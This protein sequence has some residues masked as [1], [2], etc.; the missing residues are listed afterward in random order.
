MAAGRGERF[1]GDKLWTPVAGLTILEMALRRVATCDFDVTVL[2][3]AEERGVIATELAHR[4]GIDPVVTAGGPTR[5]DSVRRGLVHAGRVDMIAVHDAARPLL[6]PAVAERVLSAAHEHGAATAA[7]P[8]VDAIKRVDAEG[9]VQQSIPRDHL[10]AIQTPQAFRAEVLRHAHEYASQFGVAGADDCELVEAAG[11]K[12]VTVEGD[13]ALF[14]VTT[15][16]QL[17]LLELLW[18]RANG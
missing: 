15:R 5:Q 18:E 17:P 1:G 10:R 4:C 3:V 16:T 2:V 8:V 7:L 9:V 13:P 12:V 14:K 11:G 6:D